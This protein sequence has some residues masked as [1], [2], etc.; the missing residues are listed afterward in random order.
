MNEA[1]LSQ[2]DKCGSAVPSDQITE[3]DLWYEYKILFLG[4]IIGGFLDRLFLWI[5][6]V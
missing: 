5:Q 6:G 2:C 4:I 3:E 1:P